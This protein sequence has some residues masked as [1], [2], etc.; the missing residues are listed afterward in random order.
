VERSGWLIEERTM[1]R[2]L[3]QLEMRSKQPTARHRSVQRLL[4]L[5]RAAI[6]QAGGTLEDCWFSREGE[7]IVAVVSIDSKSNEAAL[8]TNLEQTVPFA[9]VTLAELVPVEEVLASFEDK[10]TD[11]ILQAYTGSGKTVM[12]CYIAAKLGRSTLILVD[13]ERLATQWRDTLKILFD[14]KNDEIGIVQGKRA[15]YEY[16]FT[17]GMIQTLYDRVYDAE[18]YHAFGTII[19]DE[20]HVTGAEQFSSVLGMFPARYRLG[21]SATDRKDS[22]KR[23]ISLHLE[24]TRVRLQEER[25]PSRV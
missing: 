18:F 8:R 17:I 11:V 25:P 12:G 6:R 10:H 19:F 21:L 3:V 22:L 24:G 4:S 9:D 1:A 13:Q 2:F 23:L 14:Y 20:Y 5:T 16:D 7:Q 15:E